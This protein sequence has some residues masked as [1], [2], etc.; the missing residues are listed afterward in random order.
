[1]ERRPVEQV[2]RH[3][4]EVLEQEGLVRTLPGAAGD[5]VWV[6]FATNDYLGLSSDP[7]VKAAASRNLPRAPRASA[8]RSAAQAATR[9]TRR[10]WGR[11]ARLTSR[12]RPA[13]ARTLAG[14]SDAPRAFPP[15]A[16]AAGCR[17]RSPGGTEVFHDHRLAQSHERRGRSRWQPDR[18]HGRYD[19]LPCGDR[20]GH[21]P[22]RSP[23]D[24]RQR[25]AGSGAGSH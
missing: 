5:G 8:E 18:A 12:P 23:E 25:M 1:M 4:L 9:K 15:R 20:S 24:R 14:L 19:G 21:H 11:S 16:A 2:Y 7:A 3:H 22:R 10:S 13:P 17:P 6:N